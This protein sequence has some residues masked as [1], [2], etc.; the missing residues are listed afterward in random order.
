MNRKM[1]FSLFLLIGCLVSFGAWANS[2]VVRVGGE[3]APAP[4]LEGNYFPSTLDLFIAQSSGNGCETVGGACRQACC[5][6]FFDCISTCAPFDLQCH[7]ACMA[8][9][10]ACVDAC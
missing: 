6:A 5:F 4:V 7:L 1:M 2:D 9:D 3:I 10:S 8:Q